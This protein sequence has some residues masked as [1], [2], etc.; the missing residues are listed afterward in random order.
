[1]EQETRDA[2]EDLTS[3]IS[4]SRGLA[5]NVASTG[6]ESC[7]GWDGYWETMDMS[8][9]GR[10]GNENLTLRLVGRFADGYR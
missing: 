2:P 3:G 4:S 8:P 6:G 5:T 1:M 7:A 10:L 9:K